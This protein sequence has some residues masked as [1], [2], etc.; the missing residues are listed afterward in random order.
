VSFP[1]DDSVVESALVA[2]AVSSA[3]LL[4]LSAVA[5]PWFISRLPPDYFTHPQRNRWLSK[6]APH[7]A[8]P[9]LIVK[10]GLGVLLAIAGILMLVLPGQGLL[11]LVVALSILD[12]P[13]KYRFERWLLHRPRVFRVLNWIRTKLKCPPFERPTQQ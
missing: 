8:F 3:V 12:F 1:V 6:L 9:L 4:L 13:G 7:W 10:N 11:T 2:L 5:L